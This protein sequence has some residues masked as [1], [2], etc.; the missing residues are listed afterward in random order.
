MIKNQSGHIVN[1]ASLAGKN[2]FAGGSAYC[3]SKHSLISFSECLMLEVRHHNIKVSAICPGSVQTD[4]SPDSK[5][6]DWAL[7]PE[8]VAKTVVDVVTSS[9]RSLVSL[10]EMRPLKPQKR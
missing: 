8:D 10:V 6:K 7:S 1:I 2:N 3:A 5:E 4:F 9:N